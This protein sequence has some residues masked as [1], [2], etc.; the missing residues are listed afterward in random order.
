MGERWRPNSLSSTSPVT[1]SGR[2]GLVVGYLPRRPPTQDPTPT[3]RSRRSGPTRVPQQHD[4]WS[5]QMVFACGDLSSEVPPFGLLRE[6]S[7]RVPTFG[8]G[9]KSSGHSSADV[10][11]DGAVSKPGTLVSRTPVVWV[12]RRPSPVSEFSVSGSPDS[13]HMGFR[14]AR[15]SYPGPVRGRRRR[16]GVPSD[17]LKNSPPRSTLAV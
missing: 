5:L 9:G 7:P 12:P 13:R 1:G 11:H 6:P 8:Q 15:P 17:R 14:W 16:A 3:D 2:I 4:Y 10:A